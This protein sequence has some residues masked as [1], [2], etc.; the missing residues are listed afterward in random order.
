MQLRRG[1]ERAEIYS[2]CFSST[3]EW[4]AVSSDRGTI[5]VFSIK[6]DLRSLKLTGLQR[7]E[8]Q[9]LSPAPDSRLSLIKG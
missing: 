3:A 6:V 9:D 1:V 4:L 2:L 8:Y 7:V 5:H